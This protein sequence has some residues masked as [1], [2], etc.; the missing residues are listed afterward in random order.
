[1][2]AGGAAHAPL[3]TEP[4]ARLDEC[5]TAAF[6][7]ALPVRPKQ[8]R[9]PRHVFLLDEKVALGASATTRRHEEE[10]RD[11]RVVT[12]AAQPFERPQVSAFDR[13]QPGTG[14]YALAD[15]TLSFGILHEGIVPRSAGGGT[16]G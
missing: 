6:Q 2:T 15:R 9:Q 14:L 5:Q 7:L 1:M 12:A 3:P 8:L 4:L 13:D 10:R 11:I 16:R